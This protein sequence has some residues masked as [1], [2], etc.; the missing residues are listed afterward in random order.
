MISLSRTTSESQNFIALVKL[1]DADLAACDGEEHNFYAQFNKIAALNFVVVALEN[2]KALSCGAMKEIEKNKVEI[3]R[4]FTLPTH[5]G[6]GLAAQVLAELETW[7][8]E[9]N[10]TSAILE[11]G[12][13]Q[14]E[15]IALYTRCGYKIIPN[16]GQY[17][18][19]ENSV[20]FEKV[21]H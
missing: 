21:L 6:R 5:R 1:L 2:G 8:K 7:A 14:P 3:K 19:I 17:V 16:Y 13:K 11:T 15:A 9:L 18:G 10:Y 20:C 4:M 12:Q